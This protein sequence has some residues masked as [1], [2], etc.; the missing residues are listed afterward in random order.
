MTT[1]TDW[2]AANRAT[3]Q[4]A[5]LRVHARLQAH[6]ERGGSPVSPPVEP[7]PAAPPAPGTALGLLQAIFG[8][9]PF[10]TDL[11]VLCAGVEFEASLPLLCAAAAGDPT[12]LEPTFSLALAALD[13]PHWSAL[14]PDAPL[15]R[16]QLISVSPAALFTHGDP[17]DRRAGA[18]LPDG[19]GRTRHRLAGRVAPAPAGANPLPPR[20]ESAASRLAQLWTDDDRRIGGRGAPVHRRLRSRPE[21]RH[22]VGAQRGCSISP[23]CRLTPPNARCSARWSIARP[24]SAVARS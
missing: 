8:L 13:G 7:P 18:A 17:A 2:L 16:W 12:R 23:I 22:S 19:S 4:E 1:S 9:T 15:R 6:T 11:L 3:L 14:T 24:C 21:Q 10:E 5:L 20:H